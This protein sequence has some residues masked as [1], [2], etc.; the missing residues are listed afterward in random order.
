[1]LWKNAVLTLQ[2]GTTTLALKNFSSNSDAQ[3]LNVLNTKYFNSV[4]RLS[5]KYTSDVFIL[6]EHNIRF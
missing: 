6:L 3:I 5:Y 2:Y 4:E 1:M